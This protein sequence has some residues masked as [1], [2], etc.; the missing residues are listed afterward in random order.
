MGGGGKITTSARNS[1]DGGVAGRV[2][3]ARLVVGV[4]ET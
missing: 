1:S 4:G 2:V 3:V